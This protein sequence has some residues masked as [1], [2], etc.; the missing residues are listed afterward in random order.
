MDFQMTQNLSFISRRVQLQCFQ[1][2]LYA[3]RASAQSMH[4]VDGRFVREIL[5][6]LAKLL[7]PAA[8][9]T[10]IQRHPNT[11][12]LSLEAIFSSDAS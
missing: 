11:S 12:L 10:S 9:F 1:D 3:P 7:Q 4:F 2:E 5:K 6:T 8:Q